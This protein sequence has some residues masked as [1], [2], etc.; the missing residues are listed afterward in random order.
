M[1]LPISLIRKARSSRSMASTCLGHNLPLNQACQRGIRTMLTSKFLTDLQGSY[2]K[3]QTT[4]STVTRVNASQTHQ[5]PHY[6]NTVPTK[7][8]SLPF[9]TNS[10]KKASAQP[11]PLMT[12]SSLPATSLIHPSTMESL[13]SLPEVQSVV[14]LLNGTSINETAPAQGFVNIQ[15][16]RE[17]LQS[18]PEFYSATYLLETEL[19]V[20]VGNFKLALDSLLRYQHLLSK[21]KMKGYLKHKRHLQFIHAKL[22]FCSGQFEKC[23]SEYENLL[24]S[25]ENEVQR[26]MEQNK[27]QSKDDG[28]NVQG[29]DDPLPVIDG[30]SA[31]T[32]IG[33]S[34]MMLYFND[35]SDKSS[36]EGEIISTLETAT[37]MLLESRK[38]AIASLEHSR[39]A[40]DLGIAASISLGN[41][42]VAHHVLFS[43]ES[44]NNSSDRAIKCWKQGIMVLDTLLKGAVSTAT[45]IPNRHF[46]CME[47]LRARLH[48]NIAWALLGLSGVEKGGD[49]PEI[50]DNMLKEASNEAKK[51]LGIYD[52]L[53]NGPKFLRENEIF[54]YNDDEELDDQDITEEDKQI[55]REFEKLLVEEL[56]TRD[57]TEKGGEQSSI[58]IDTPLSS[59][60]FDYSRSE[61]ARAL[62]LVAHCYALAGSAV[63]AEGLFQ[64]AL[65]ASSSCPYGQIVGKSGKR[66]DGVIEKGISLS[67]P[68]LGLIARDVRLWYATLCDNWEKRTGDASRLRMN[69]AKIEQDGVLKDIFCSLHSVNKNEMY[70]AEKKSPPGILTSFWMLNPLDFEE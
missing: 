41:L 51:A 52:E 48:C 45:I 61:S 70:D 49:L 63:T 25:M 3:T 20:F 35:H 68:S 8:I 67:S 14:G 21:Q 39:L 13:Q 64:S 6:N 18:I 60:W 53:I 38:D 12:P 47:S 33:L 7:L 4:L 5:L 24:E 2:A 15:R 16:A 65:D 59:Y 23:L 44:V 10:K 29:N 42:G 9:S 56:Q 46:Q 31:L 17:I 62:G 37:D 50:A 66:M 28:G 1:S 34:N 57:N 55:K 30:A 22:L 43:R 69:A 26:Q 58:P 19:H 36:Y 32:G 40:L 27:T 11:L 54:D